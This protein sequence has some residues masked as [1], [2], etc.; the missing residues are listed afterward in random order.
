LFT[1]HQN[2]S[3][4]KSNAAALAS[5]SRPSHEKSRRHHL[6]KHTIDNIELNGMMHYLSMS[7]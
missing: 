6:I 2:I 3:P 5:L 7:M 4:C 1:P